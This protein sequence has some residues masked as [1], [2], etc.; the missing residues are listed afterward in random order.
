MRLSV[1]IPTLNEATQIAGAIAALRRHCV[2]PP[3]DLVVI[4]SGSVDDT[5]SIAR[6][7]GARV[8]VDRGLGSRAAACNAGAARTRGDALLFLHADSRVPQGY[9]EVIR[10]T[11]SGSRVAGGAFEFALAGPELRLRLVEIVNRVRYRTRGRFYGDQGIFVRRSVLEAVGGYP[12]VP[13]L[14][15]ARLCARARRIGPMRL[16]RDVM[17]TS[18]RRFY[19]RGILT[20]LVT[21]S[22]I[23]LVAV[24]GLDPG[25]FGAWYRRNNVRRGGIGRRLTAP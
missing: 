18:P 7:C 21:D 25:V 6:D 9:D 15:D 12:E 20:T 1:V 16:V 23:V 3:P 11:L 8:S 13:I 24:V 10:K 14:E 22:L 19:D 2:Y 5:V 4:D 17:P